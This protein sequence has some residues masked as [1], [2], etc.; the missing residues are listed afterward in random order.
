MS[1]KDD[2]G[3]AAAMQRAAD[4]M[5]IARETLAKVEL[6]D[7]EKLE[8]LIQQMEAP[9]L[10][11]LLQA[12]QLTEGDLERLG[13][14]PRLMSVQEDL[15]AELQDKAKEGIT[16]EDRA[17]LEEFQRMSDSRDQARQA[18]IMQ[19]MAETGT[20]GSGQ[21]LAAQIASGQQA[22]MNDAAAARDMARQASEA[23]LSGLEKA[24]NVAGG[25]MA[26]KDAVAA[27]AA[28]ARD[29]RNKFNA[30]NRQ[31]VAGQN[32]AS[33]QRISE[34][35]TSTRNLRRG[36]LGAL[37]QQDFENRYRK[38]GG[39]AQASQNMANMYMTQ[40]QMAQPKRGLGGAIGTA[41]GAA[42]GSYGGVEGATLGA[43]IGGATG[44]QFKD[45]GRKY[46]D[47]TE[48]DEFANLERERKKEELKNDFGMDRYKQAIY[49]KKR[50]TD[51][52][53][54]MF[55]ASP[56]GKFLGFG[57]SDD[58][59]MAKPA[60]AVKPAIKPKEESLESLVAQGKTDSEVRAEADRKKGMADLGEALAAGI[61]KKEEPRE[62]INTPMADLRESR[63]AN[64]GVPRGMNYENGGEGAIIDS[65]MDSFSG[66]ML[67]DR[68][69]DG[70]MV[71]NVKQ[72]ERLNQMLQEL[73]ALRRM[74][75][76][77]EDGPRVDE[78]LDA[79]EFDLNE[80]QQEAL[81]ALLRGEIDPED[82]PE[83]DI[84]ED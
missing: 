29:I 68:I 3:R 10:V 60:P 2:G 65:G 25:M 52:A 75:A 45:G 12:E 31:D 66:D 40:A 22:A 70:E 83:E 9:E 42:V 39:Q 38:A 79:G 28:Q 67:E 81:M 5:R 34:A 46:E 49:G 44:S 4:E 23:K 13:L 64:G 73:R 63:F 59:P 78:Q 32:L 53:N 8:N 54:K 37:E 14:D 74:H 56:L 7:K 6:P 43:Q 48:F 36:Q 30:M 33:R 84:L 72:Q 80:E 58:K 57:Q 17:K 18:S 61:R 77:V 35:G 16:P 21:Q 19:R 69:N 15:L 27:R 41:L 11:G 82:L 50:T 51:R 20:L 76:G 71:L 1:S 24:S 62:F 26:S 55:G 47:G